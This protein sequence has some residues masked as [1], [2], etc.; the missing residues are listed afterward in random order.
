MLLECGVLLISGI[1]GGIVGWFATDFVARP[2]RQ[3]FQ[4]R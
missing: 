3:F 4:L 2:V 1:I